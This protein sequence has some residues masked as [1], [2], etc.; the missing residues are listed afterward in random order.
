MMKKIVFILMVSALLLSCN[1]VKEKTKK[2]I[3]KS[4]EMVGKTATEF[5]E[6]VATGVKES[7][8]CEILLSDSLIDKGIEYGKF[9]FS[10]SDSGT[11]H[12]MTIYLIFNKDFDRNIL[13]KVT[14][15]Q[16]QE[17]GRAKIPVTGKKDEAKYIDFIFDDRT[18]VERKSKI[19]LDISI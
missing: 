1:K 18:K 13:A 5:S 10:S 12:I 3:N 14:D 2:T 8:E 16:G 17:Y 7:L 6:G 15:K 9:H 4:G 19:L 11:K